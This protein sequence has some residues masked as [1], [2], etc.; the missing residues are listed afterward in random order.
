MGSIYNYSG[1]ET[2]SLR[3]GLL[4]FFFFLSYFFGEGWLPV[5]MLIGWRAANNHVLCLWAKNSWADDMV[6]VAKNKM[7]VSEVCFACLTWLYRLFV[8]MLIS[9][10]NTYTGCGRPTLN[11]IECFWLGS[12]HVLKVYSN[13]LWNELYNYAQMYRNVLQTVWVHWRVPVLLWIGSEVNVNADHEVIPLFFSKLPINV[14]N[15]QFVWFYWSI[16]HGMVLFLP[17]NGPVLLGSHLPIT[18]PD[19]TGSCVFPCM[20]VQHY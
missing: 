8:R 5:C 10:T 6:Q 4:S 2:L 17:Q 20:S 9:L 1:C 7:W 19:T 16:I 14:P 3:I 15:W 11:F 18:A 12:V 13:E